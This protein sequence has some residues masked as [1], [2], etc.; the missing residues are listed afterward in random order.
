M[1]HSSLFTYFILPIALVAVGALSFSTAHAGDCGR[2]PVYDRDIGG[3]ITTGARVRSIA[4]MEGSVVLTTLPVGT[5]ITII[6]ETDGWYKVRTAD[7]LTGWIGQWLI[8]PGGSTLP[9]PE[10]PEVSTP[11]SVGLVK[12]LNSKAVYY[13]KDGKRYAFPNARVFNTWYGDYSSVV[14]ISDGDL[15]NF[16]LV[17]NV[18]Y[19]PGIRLIK[20]TTDPKVYAVSRY[21][22]LRW[23]KTEAAARDLYGTGWYMGIHDV[24]DQF[25]VNYLVGSPIEAATNFDMN[26]ET[27]VN[28]VDANIR[29]AG[30]TL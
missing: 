1:K 10:Q 20:I 14:T 24:P 22:V 6:A 7:G 25:F 9:P 18:T 15:A 23:V 28:T 30:F 8:E 19:R 13:V 27:S 11:P 26:T 2:D 5:R 16:Q 21:G 29:P 4:C 12:G 3:T 17:G